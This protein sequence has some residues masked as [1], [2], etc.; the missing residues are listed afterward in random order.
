MKLSIDT[1]PLWDGFRQTD[2]CPF[3]FIQNRLEE[4]FLETYLG[5]S[6]ME[7]DVR[8]EVN[9][10][11]F[12]REHYRQLYA[13]PV[14]KLGLAL[15]THTHLKETLGGVERQMEAIDRRCEESTLLKRATG[16]KDLNDA[17][18]A[19]ARSVKEHGE[20]CVV[21]ERIELHM[22]RYYE[23][24]YDL[25]ARD[26]EFAALF[27]GCRGFC[28]PHWSGL[29]ASCGGP[30]PGKDKLV[31]LKRVNELERRAL[32]ALEEDL[33]WFIQKFDYRNTEKPWGNAKD[34]LP[35]AVNAL[36]GQLV[37]DETVKGT[38]K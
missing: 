38:L 12:C 15:M 16:A 23:T 9:R 3:C 4:L 10:K 2:C 21:C 35:R 17:L 24:A 26:R 13:Q 27:E 18:T 20:S 11:G 37:Q 30:L 5:D 7:P 25:W 19:A 32:G 8:V 36:M 22:A 29:L 33:A 6:V 34:A 14:S 31:F 28:L 1:L